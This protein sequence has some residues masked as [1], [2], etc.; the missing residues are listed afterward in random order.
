MDDV[1]SSF[2]KAD[3]P[4][5]VMV[6]GLDTQLITVRSSIRVGAVM[7]TREE[8]GVFVKGVKAGEFD[9]LTEQERDPADWL[10]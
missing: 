5:C 7:F 8:W 9:L 1:T 4:M 3:D 2:C 10:G 6:G